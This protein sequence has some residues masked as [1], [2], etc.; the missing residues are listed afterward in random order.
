MM[1]KDRCLIALIA[2]MGVVGMSGC[3][4]QVPYTPM[5]GS[6]YVNPAMKVKDLGRV[7]LVELDNKTSYPEK[8]EE[9]SEAIYVALQKCQLFGMTTIAQD[10]S[11]WHSLQSPL[12]ANYDAEQLM[13]MRR[14]LESDAILTGTMTQF[15]PYP[16]MSVGL[17]IRLIDLRSGELLWAVE[18]VWDCGDAHTKIGIERYLQDQIGTEGS[19][20]Q[21]TLV[22]T[23]SLNFFRFISY[24]LALTLNS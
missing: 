5:E 19:A 10:D 21:R 9:L 1:N 2:L 3:R 11:R 17:R 18:Q 20:L 16:H 7:A 15:A 6:Y 23:S 24:E 4:S 14:V 22:T 12:D 8:S 13:E